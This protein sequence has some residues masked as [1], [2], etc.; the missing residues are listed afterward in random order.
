MTEDELFK[1]AI[2]MVP[3]WFEEPV[4]KNFH[5][6]NTSPSKRHKAYHLANPT[7]RSLRI[8]DVLN[9][10]L[11]LFNK[12]SVRNA[13]AADELFQQTLIV[14]WLKEERADIAWKKIIT[15]A[16]DIAHR[17]Y[18]NAPVICNLIVTSEDVGG[19]GIEEWNP[20]PI[21]VPDDQKVLDQLG[22]SPLTYIAI[23]KDMNFVGYRSIAANS[24]T[25]CGQGWFHPEFLHPFSSLLNSDKGYQCSIHVTARHDIIVMDKD[26]MVCSRRKGGWKAYDPKSVKATLGTA[27]DHDDKAMSQVVS[28]N[29]YEVLLDLSFKRH[30]ALL[31]FDPKGEVIQQVQNPESII[32]AQQPEG[33]HKMIAKGIRDLAFGGR[34]GPLGAFKRLLIEIASVDGAVIFDNN[35]VLAFGAIIK[36]HKKVT[37]SR[38]ARSTAAMSAYHWGG[39]P[40]KVSSDGDVTVYF[41]NKVSGEIGT[42]RFS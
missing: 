29:L 32:G 36:P 10:D 18:E 24:I 41:K 9:K 7:D 15:Y 35:H 38:G 22:A 19:L 1:A 6:I 27:L 4:S 8:R 25:E 16:H 37:G 13:I 11:P 31:I 30:G 23:D 21:D 14:R 2:K 3:H 26:G 28:S 17:T 5:W 33:V 39:K 34:G 20:R 42:M 12:M 40:F